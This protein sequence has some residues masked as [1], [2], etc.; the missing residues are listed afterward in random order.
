MF[1]I[2]NWWWFYGVKFYSFVPIC[3]RFVL[4]FSV[5]I[6]ITFRKFEFFAGQ[7][8]SRDMYFTRYV[9]V[10]ASANYSLLGGEWAQYGGQ[11]L[12]QF[13]ILEYLRNLHE[14]NEADWR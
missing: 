1:Q 2:I 12:L 3:C 13:G 5:F 4:W 11:L 10:R 7:H 6:A 8:A 9:G 14:P